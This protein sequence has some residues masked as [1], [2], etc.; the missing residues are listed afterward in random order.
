LLDPRPQ[1]VRNRDCAAAVERHESDGL[2]HSQV[3]D[4]I[5]LP[6]V[7]QLYRGVAKL[8]DAQL[9]AQGVSHPQGFREFALHADRGRADAPIADQIG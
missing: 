2:H 1:I 5:L 3:L 8:E 4:V 7:C 6:A 9:E